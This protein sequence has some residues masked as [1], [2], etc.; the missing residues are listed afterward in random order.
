MDRTGHYSLDLLFTSATEEDREPPSPRHHK[1]SMSVSALIPDIS[2]SAPGPNPFAL[3]T[4][5]K[6]RPFSWDSPELHHGISERISHGNF[7][8]LEFT[9][10]I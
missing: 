9:R 8:Y 2:A 1:G 3:A 4:S 7:S 5:E 6:N 10:N